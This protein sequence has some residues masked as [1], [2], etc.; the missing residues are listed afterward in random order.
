MA[1][2][3][4]E[5]EAALTSGGTLLIWAE[6]YRH[7][8]ADA[9]PS[10]RSRLLALGDRAR[11]LARAGGLEERAARE[12]LDAVTAVNRAIRRLIDDRRASTPYRHAVEARGAGDLPR[13]AALLPVIFADLHAA[14]PPAAAFW[15]PVWQNRGRPLPA[16]RIATELRDLE[17]LGIPATGDDLTAGV[18]PDLPGV[19]LSASMPLGAP[20]A[21][22]YE[23]TT[24]PLPCLCLRD[25]L[26]VIP[27]D[28]LRLP[29]VVALAR[30]DEPLDEW[31][32][33]PPAYLDALERACGQQGLAVTR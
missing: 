23:G 7:A 32:A 17:G 15:T 33:D 10:L 12:V 1:D 27:V 19:L 25:D 11:R 21:L 26:V 16:E 22:R 18:D 9:L 4:A 6:K 20:L 14:A 5:L 28:R 8:D 24:L 29:F 3:A 30:P 13:L 2:A 31:V